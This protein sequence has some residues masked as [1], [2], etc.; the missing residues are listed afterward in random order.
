MFSSTK[1]PP[2]GLTEDAIAAATGLTTAQV[3]ELLETDCQRGM[4][5]RGADGTFRLSEGAERCFGEAL[6]ALPDGP[7]SL[8]QRPGRRAA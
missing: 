4:V 5:V 1:T 6:R 3:L 8:G 2:R 7:F